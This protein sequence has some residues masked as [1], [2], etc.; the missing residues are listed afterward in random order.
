LLRASIRLYVDYVCRRAAVHLVGSSC[1]DSA[2]LRRGSV[3]AW[4][5]GECPMGG[6]RA[7]HCE[8]AELRW[9]A[10]AASQPKG[11]EKPI[12]SRHL[13]PFLPGCTAPTPPPRSHVPAAACGP[14]LR[15]SLRRSSGPHSER[16][17]ERPNHAGRL[18]RPA[19]SPPPHTG[20]DPCRTADLAAPVCLSAA[21][22][23]KRRRDV[24]PSTSE[25]SPSHPPTERQ[26]EEKK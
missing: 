6:R 4:H 19:A 8:P 11:Q 2:W 12:C 1:T 3:R 5:R 13:D 15:Y 22:Y 10:A 23:V 20:R 26:K 16:A 21:M 9:A 24:S 25:S 17:S 18:L 7:W 14:A